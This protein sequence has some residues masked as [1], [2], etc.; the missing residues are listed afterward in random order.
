M[1]ADLEPDIVEV[2]LLACQAGGL[3]ENAAHAIEQNI[4]ARYGG[5]RVR[6]PKRRKWATEEERAAVVSDVHADLPASELTRKHGISRATLY[7]LLKK[8]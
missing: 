1:D 4:R 6:I 5:Q 7:R 3:D 2:I 8:K